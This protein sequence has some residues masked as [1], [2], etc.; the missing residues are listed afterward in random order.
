MK[1]V[2][3]AELVLCA[4]PYRKRLD[5]LLVFQ[6]KSLFRRFVKLANS[7]VQQ[8]NALGPLLNYLN[9]CDTNAV[10]VGKVM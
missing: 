10:F 4:Y 3:R 7:G 6:I 2:V 9:S 1:E 8:G 5:S